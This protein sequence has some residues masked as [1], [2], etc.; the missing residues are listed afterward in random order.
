MERNGN[1]GM[2]LPGTRESWGTPQ[3]RVETQRRR[4]RAGEQGD[5][6]NRTLGMRDCDRSWE[7]RIPKGETLRE[8]EAE[9]RETLEAE[10][11]DARGGV[12][13]AGR[14]GVPVL[15]FRPY[16]LFGSE[17]SVLLFRPWRTQPELSPQTGV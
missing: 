17:D 1:S 14:N 15:S 4:Q 13:K 2:T 7:A 5:K 11:P 6:I 12:G 3:D 16:R 9:P 10:A 8:T